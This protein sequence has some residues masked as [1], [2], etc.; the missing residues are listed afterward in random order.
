MGYGI[1]YINAYWGIIDA[2]FNQ[3]P[4]GNVKIWCTDNNGQAEN[5]ETQNPQI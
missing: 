4:V 2:Y 3:I 5:S 1:S